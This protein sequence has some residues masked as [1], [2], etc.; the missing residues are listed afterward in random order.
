MNGLYF[1]H[2]ATTP[3]DPRVL[4]V[5][6]P[7]LTEQFYNPSSV[8]SP[9]RKVRA[10]IDDARRTVASLL[11]ALP[12][13]IYFTSSGTEADNWAI[14][15]TL[16]NSKR[17]KHIVSTTIEHHG[18]LY[19]LRHLEKQGYEV[20]YVGVNHEGIVDPADIE[21]AIRPETALVSVMMANNEVGAIQPIREI[22]E[23][24]KK[25][26]VRM[27]TDAVQAAGHIPVDVKDLGVDLL[28]ISAHKFGGPKGTG[29]L[30]IRKGAMI[31]PMMFGGAQ[32]R[33]KRAGTESP[34]GIVGLA[35]ALEIAVQERE[36][37]SKRIRFMRDCLTARILNEI[38]HV[39]LNGPKVQGLE[40]CFNDEGGTDETRVA[41][42][43]RLPGN[44]NVSFRFIEG[45]SLLLH[46][47]MHNCYAS[48][49]SACSSGSLD[50]SHVLMAMGVSHE[51]ANGAIRFSIGKNNTEEDLV[52]LM[53]VLKR[54][55]EKLRALSPLYDDFIKQ[56]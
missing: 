44:V 42:D 21:H 18:V 14:M 24:C 15:G 11:G 17:G 26:G 55:V 33:G 22:A 31:A 7:L 5:M 8:Y 30:Y 20:T 47:D 37:E 41:V 19:F 34:A 16:E 39:V 35:K 6:M 29:V 28:S 43:N 53:D 48:T 13:E 32:E 10:M 27:H 56:Q 49:G 12:E 2:A 1:D 51:L 4:E 9:G 36:T 50:P 46:L 25:H 45:E 23:I 40:K 54:S 3:L 52:I 38:P